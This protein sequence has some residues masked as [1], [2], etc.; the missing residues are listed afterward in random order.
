M[1]KLSKLA[2][3]VAT[4]VIAASATAESIVATTPAGAIPA[5]HQSVNDNWTNGSDQ[6][7]WKNGTDQL[8]WRN[9]FWTPATANAQCDGAIVAQAPVAPAPGPVTSQKIRYR[10]D[11]LFDFDK[12]TLKPE[13]ITELNQL[14]TKLN[15]VNIEAIIAT[16][17]TDQLGSAPYNKRL[18]LRRAN[19]VKS[20]LVSKGIDANRI[21]TEGKGKLNPLIRLLDC[22]HTLR[23]GRRA[24]HSC[25]AQNR[26]VEVEVVGTAKDRTTQIDN[27]TNE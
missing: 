21:F 2:F 24:L 26:R 8:C 22:A 17:Y 9:N 15:P 20:Y 4:A 19:A 5:S 3:V 25:I 23:A 16:G 13:G 27:S 12:A 14:V 18:S 1:K 7:V 6:Y 11:A 10:A